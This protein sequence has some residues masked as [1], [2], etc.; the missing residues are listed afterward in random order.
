MSGDPCGND[1]EGVTCDPGDVV[2]IGLELVCVFFF[3]FFKATENLSHWS[4]SSL[5]CF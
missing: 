5:F 3:F 1:W 4:L 2:V